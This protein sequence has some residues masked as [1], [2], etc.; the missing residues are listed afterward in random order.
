MK[1]RT[2]DYPVDIGQTLSRVGYILD[3]VGQPSDHIRVFISTPRIDKFLIEMS[4]CE[5]RR[6]LKHPALAKSNRKYELIYHEINILIRDFLSDGLDYCKEH[7]KE[8][9]DLSAC[10]STNRIDSIVGQP[11]GLQITIIEHHG[12]GLSEI[13][14]AEFLEE[15]LPNLIK[16]ITM[17]LCEENSK[18]YS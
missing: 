18:G 7:F 5:S 9:I 4:E 10:V 1:Q 17:L 6:D 8:V 16:R 2:N 15:Q 11:H 14:M 12:T 3:M 13:P